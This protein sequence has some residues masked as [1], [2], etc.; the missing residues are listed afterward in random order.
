MEALSDSLL[1]LGS[2]EVKVSVIHK[3]IGEIS[4]NDVLLAAASRA[5]IIGFNVRPNLKARKLAESE[6][7]DI[8]LHNIIYDVINEVKL[9][10]EGLLEPEKS[11]EILATVEVRQTFKVPKIGMVAGCYV[12]DG[13]IVRNNKV[14][15]LRDGFVVF[16]GS[17]NALKRFKDDVRE[18][19][20][21]FECGIS[22]ENYNDIKVGDIIESYTI[23]E[24]KRK[25][26][27]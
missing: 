5:I 9:A 27:H 16:D 12:L 1:K 23:V 14:R 17:I 24:T 11:E 19:E 3:G 13:K 8:R 10:L 20:Q 2:N 22:L 6:K 26:E 25:L 15:L 4:E 7:V 21:G 18:V